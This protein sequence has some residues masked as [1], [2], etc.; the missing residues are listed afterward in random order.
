MP[1][2]DVC[3]SKCLTLGK[4]QHFLV[5]DCSTIRAITSFFF[6]IKHYHLTILY[7][8]AELIDG[9]RLNMLFIMALVEI[10][11]LHSAW[12]SKWKHLTKTTR[13]L[14]R[15]LFVLERQN[16]LKWIQQP[17]LQQS[18]R[19]SCTTPGYFWFMDL[20]SAQSCSLLK[21]ML[22]FSEVTELCS[23]TGKE[24]VVVTAWHPWHAQSVIS[25]RVEVTAEFCTHSL[26]LFWL[27]LW[28]ASGSNLVNE[29][30][31]SCM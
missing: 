15:H 16:I 28:E 3:S 4:K 9:I 7:V 21:Q 12:I 24:R 11:D 22:L 19:V 26:G 6:L 10:S 31:V 29:N 27:V 30:V 25:A 14:L 18:N 2:V 5:L 13:E 20:A 23:N 17:V 8:N 1:F